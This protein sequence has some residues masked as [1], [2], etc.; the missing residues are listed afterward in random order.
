M[1]DGP[2][3]FD[4]E[5]EQARL[6]QLKLL[7]RRQIS[8]CTDS[9]QRVNAVARR[10]ARRAA[11]TVAQLRVAER[12]NHRHFGGKRRLR[13]HDRSSACARLTR[14]KERQT[15]SFFLPSSANACRDA[16][17]RACIAANKHT[18]RP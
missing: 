10:S 12:R 9:K 3:D 1:H 4:A 17:E 5:F 8:T 6:G 15:R 16:V 18:H 14:D 2:T 13:A 7:H 11:R